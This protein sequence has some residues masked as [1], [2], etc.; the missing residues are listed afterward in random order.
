MTKHYQAPAQN[1]GRAERTRDDRGAARD[2][3]VDPSNTP[4]VLVP[5]RRSP[6]EP[7]PTPASGGVAERRPEGGHAPARWEPE[8]LSPDPRSV[9]PGI[10]TQ[11]DPKDPPEEDGKTGRPDWIRLVGDEDQR[12]WVFQLLTHAFGDLTIAC[13]G[14]KYFKTGKL[15]PQG[16]LLSE[17]HKNGIVMVDYQGSCL[18]STETDHVLDLV[19]LIMCHGFHCTRI[20]LAVDH[21]FM[22]LDLYAN[23]LR[24]CDAGELCQ[25]R[26]YSPDPEYKAD[27]TP[28]RLLLK[29]G[30]RESAVCV[31]FYDKGLETKTHTRG[32]WERIEVEFKDTRANEVCIDLLNHRQRLQ[33]RLW[34]YVIGAMDFRAVNGRGELDRRPR[35]AWW[36]KYV[37]GQRPERPSPSHAESGLDS[38][39]G[40]FRSSVGPRLIQLARLMGQSP[41]EFTESLLEGVDPARTNTLATI[42]AMTRSNPE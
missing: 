24:S 7:S 16:V 38:W 33:E 26:S 13:S 17:G 9:T 3:T 27:G 42:D 34:R 2:L 12:D 29:L 23:A 40:W 19:E 37:G 22:G 15:W 14:A 30:K 10:E 25:L 11:K 4:P 28:I 8:G 36:C 18:A 20:D 21:Y 5:A 6:S 32:V 41:I 39:R 35:A 1:P 31:R